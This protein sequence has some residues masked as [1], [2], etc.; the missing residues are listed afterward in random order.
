M[1]YIVKISDKSGGKRWRLSNVFRGILCVL[2]EIL[3]CSI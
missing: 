3:Y 2:E 1:V